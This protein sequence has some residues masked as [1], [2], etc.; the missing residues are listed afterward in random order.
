[1]QSLGKRMQSF[2][3]NL[4]KEMLEVYTPTGHETKL[5][6]FL[7]ERMKILELEPYIDEAGNVIGEF[8]EGTPTILFCGHMDTVEG[9]L[10]INLKEG[11]L[12]GRGAVDA[13]TSLAAMV[14]AASNL[15]KSN[16][17][18]KLIVAGVIDEEGEGRGIKQLI[19]DGIKAD[20][21]VFGEPSGVNQITVAYKGSLHIK[22]SV[23]TITGH[24]SAPWLFDNAVEKAFEIYK[25]LRTIDF[26]SERKD[27]RFYSLS[28]C[29][30][31]IAGGT[32]SS[33][34]PSK[35]SLH[36][37]FRIP[38]LIST[39]DVFNE[40]RRIG[41]EYELQHPKVGLR[42]E[43][44][45]S[46]EPYETSTNSL[47]IRSL[48]WAIRMIRGKPATWVRKTGTSDMNIYGAS[49]KI[50]I[51]AY[52]AGE[53]IL[54]HTNNESINLKEYGDSIQVLNKG[55][56]RLLELSKKKLT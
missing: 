31:K 39:G 24:S 12:Y 38:P 11:R 45:D 10:P 15:I 4:L 50:P 28:S 20:Y 2:A 49:I 55:I 41:N 37:D 40:I 30:T 56:I 18:G 43:A 19:K 44:L 54:D 22:V 29:L 51:V 46:C 9:K 34:I 6:Q 52:G 1:M 27:S 21:A 35:C 14:M 48:S 7:F 36:I 8:G 3:V 32:S 13:K 5:A 33:R 16:F 25:L 17:T 26:S 53:S 42:I 23:Q 47:L